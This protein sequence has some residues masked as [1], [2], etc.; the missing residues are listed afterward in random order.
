MV[1]TG[2]DM[3][4]MG[5]G[6]TF[7]SLKIAEDYDP[8]FPISQHTYNCLGLL[9]VVDY[10]DRND[11]THQIVIMDE[12]QTSAPSNKWYSTSNEAI[13]YTLSVFRRLKSACIICLPSF[14]SIDKRIRNLVT[15]Y[16]F[17]KPVMFGGKM[18]YYLYIF[19]LKTDQFGG[20]PQPKMIKVY[21]EDRGCKTI[22]RRIEM[23]PPSQRLINEY[24]EKDKKSKQE[25]RRKAYELAQGY[26]KTIVGKQNYE[27]NIAET[28]ANH[29]DIVDEY[30]RKGKVSGAMVSYLN[31]GISRADCANIATVIN[32]IKQKAEKSKDGGG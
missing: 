4:R 13:F 11:L 29:P 25:I 18:H 21:D 24:K 27:A 17:V 26:E 20:D 8:N 19:Q 1:I 23:L 15:L 22:I 28:L 3:L 10:F 6:K 7:S 2:S 9:D 30:S 32:I 14:A 5:N 12:A 31:K 16:G